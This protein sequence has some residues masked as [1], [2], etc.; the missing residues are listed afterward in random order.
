M[1]RR[2]RT[3]LAVLLVSAAVLILCAPVRGGQDVCVT[4]SPY[5]AW[6]GGHINLGPIGATAWPD[7]HR[8]HVVHVAGGSPAAG[9]LHAGDVV[10]GANGAPFAPERD[11]RMILGKAIGHSETPAAGGRLRLQI[12]RRGRKMSVDVVLR[13]VGPYGARWPFDCA[14]SRRVLADA[15]AY[16]ASQQFPN[17]YVEGE[18]GMATAWAGLL[19]LASGDVRYL[20][21]ARRAAYYLVDEHFA[22]GA[23]GLN[24][25]PRGYACLFL[26]EYYLATGDSAVYAEI[27]ALAGVL[28]KWQMACGSWGHNG[29]YDGYGAVNEVGLA[30]FNGLILAGECGIRVDERAV[31]R[32]ELFFRKFAGKGW[33]PYGDHKPYRGDNGA[34]KDAQAAVAFDLLGQRDIVR[35]Y[36][37]N[38][39]AAYRHR[40]QGHT[41]SFFSIMWGPLAAV[42][43][44]EAPFREFMDYQKWFYDMSRTW[45]GGI[46]SLPNEENFSGRTPGTYTWTGPRFTTG[47]LGLVYAIPLRKLR[48]L[49][50]PRKAFG[51]KAAGSAGKAMDLIFAKKWKQLDALLAEAGAKETALLAEIRQAVSLQKKSVAMAMESFGRNIDEGDV[52]RSSELLKS[53]ERLLGGESADLA[54]ARKTMAANEQWVAAG[55]RYYQTWYTMHEVASEYWHYYGRRAARELR[56]AEPVMPLNWDRLAPTSEAAPR[57][58]KVRHWDGAVTAADAAAG[59]LGRWYAPG[60]DDAKWTDVKGPLRE[61]RGKGDA[62]EPR[63]ILARKTFTVGDVS[64]AKARLILKLTAR[65][66]LVEVYINGTK[67]ARIVRRPHKPDPIPLTGAAAALLKP[68]A[69]TLAVHCILKTSTSRLGRGL[70][71]GLQAAGRRPN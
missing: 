26:S 23:H 27:K 67:V 62:E 71:I 31:R 70:D 40:E 47:G 66:C 13:V 16:L 20:D 35:L 55:K 9:V 10:T 5:I 29:P 33:I 64:Y 54:A 18:V 14:K 49:G 43:A 53:L 44:G 58:W 11:S 52:Y 6:R 4:W 34:G 48:I 50:A 17:G 57:A 42:R 59:S 32:S 22:T 7:G 39:A 3:N 41:G 2:L 25:W 8:L 45:D 1:K 61:Q 36:S 69:N 15:C 56:L 46:M 24:N 65:D 51:R 30:C 63:H 21:N 28:A 38:V 60:Y 12:E 68:G 37:T 19:F